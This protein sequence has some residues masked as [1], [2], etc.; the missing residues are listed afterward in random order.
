MIVL[1]GLIGAGKSSLAKILGKTLDTKVFYEAVDDNPVLDLYYQNP[2]QYAFLLQIYFLNKRFKAIK[3]ANKVKNTILDRSIFEDDLF[4]TLNYKNGNV[5]KTEC[6]TYKELLGNMLEEV[7]G[8]PKKS[9][10]ILIYIDVTFEKMLERIK[11]RG[12]DYEQIDNHPE[13]YDYYQ[14]LH[15]EYQTWITQYNHSPKLIIDGNRYDFIENTDDK[16]SVL[17]TILSCLK[18]QGCL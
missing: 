8:M 11:K 14:Q 16:E 18:E 3:E 1:A 12:R 15:K 2:K 4:L 7:D 10:D 6:E 9:P 17:H 5:S 13:L